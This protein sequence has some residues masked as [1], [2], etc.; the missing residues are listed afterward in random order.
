MSFLRYCY[1]HESIYLVSFLSWDVDACRSRPL[2]ILLHLGYRVSHYSWNVLNPVSLR[3]SG[4]ST[5]VDQIPRSILL[6]PGHGALISFHDR[7]KK[8]Y[9]SSFEDCC[10]LGNWR[11]LI[12]S[13]TFSYPTLHTKEP[14]AMHKSNCFLDILLAMVDRSRCQSVT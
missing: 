1:E 5:L 7:I 11:L 12:M 4:M 10:L 14:R 2:S 3:L 9:K 13:L 8:C 6:H